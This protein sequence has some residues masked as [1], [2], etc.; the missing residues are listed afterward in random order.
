M[1]ENRYL[2]V[3]AG[4]IGS[5]LWPVSTNNN[6]KQFQ[7]MLGTGKTLL[8]ETVDRVKNIF[9]KQ[10]IYILTNEKYLAIVKDQLPFLRDR[11]ILVEPLVKNTAPC[12]L[13]GLKKVIKDNKDANV[14]ITPADHTI[15]KE[16]EFKQAISSILEITSKNDIIVTIGIVPSY[17]S[18]GY[19]YIQ[20]SERTI[21]LL[22]KVKN[23]TEKPDIETAYR[24][25]ETKEFFWNSGIFIT[26]A[27][28]MINEFRIHLPDITQHF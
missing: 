12:I 15:L 6:P 27:K 13:Y 19:G 5:R 11:Q 28:N 21:G 10:N 14:V 3:M 20:M 17:P 2:L 16:T 7:D 4:G 22:N 24:F 26:N 1:I 23:F 8:Q 9:L 25:I 18:T